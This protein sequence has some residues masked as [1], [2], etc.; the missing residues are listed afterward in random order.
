MPAS[1]FLAVVVDD[2]RSQAKDDFAPV[3]AV[4]EVTAEVRVEDRDAFA[5]RWTTDATWTAAAGDPFGGVSM[6]AHGAELVRFLRAGD[7]TSG[8]EV[9]DELGDPLGAAHYFSD[10]VESFSEIAPDQD[11][12]GVNGSAL[13]APEGAVSMGAEGGLPA[14]CVWLEAVVEPLAGTLLVTD[15]IALV[16]ASGAVCE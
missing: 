8:V 11:Q 3:A 1:G 15:W 2:A 14:E 7:P 6:V 5:L 9:T 4:F 12:T 10:A 16:E 13:I